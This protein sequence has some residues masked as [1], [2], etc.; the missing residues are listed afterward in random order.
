MLD[1]GAFQFALRRALLVNAGSREAPASQSHRFPP[2][3]PPSLACP[4]IRVHFLT[5]SLVGGHHIDSHSL[6][7][8]HARPLRSSACRSWSIDGKRVWSSFR[9]I[10]H[11]SHARCCPATK[12][13]RRTRA[14]DRSIHHDMGTI[15]NGHCGD[16]EGPMPPTRRPAVCGYQHIAF[17]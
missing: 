7:H 6:R 4:C 2:A 17:V 3:A 11:V 14:G 12:T 5:V 13:P 10:A 8:A 16:A 1:A 15:S 9:R